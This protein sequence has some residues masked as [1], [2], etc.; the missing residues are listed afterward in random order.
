MS[1]THALR[2][3]RWPTAGNVKLT[4]ASSYVRYASRRNSLRLAERPCCEFICRLCSTSPAE[5]NLVLVHLLLPGK[6]MPL[7]S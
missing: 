5:W 6:P 3:A 2:P 4:P 1:T 7:G